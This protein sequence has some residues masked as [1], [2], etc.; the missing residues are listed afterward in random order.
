MG[1]AAL[2]YGA[3]CYLAFLASAAYAV[4][5]VGDFGVPTT[6]DSGPTLPPFESAVTDLVLLAL[7]ALQHSVMARPAFKRWWSRFV[8]H[9]IERSTYVLA[10]SVALAL[11]CWQWQPL[12]RLLWHADGVLRMALLW[13]CAAG[14]AMAV[15]S[16]F[17][18]SHTDLFGLRQT[19]LRCRA[20]RHTPVP[21]TEAALYKF[22]RHPMMLGFLIAFWSTPD[23]SEGHLLFAAATTVYILIG[24]RLEERDLDL[25]LGDDYRSYR[26]RVGMLLPRMRK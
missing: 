6:I 2:L 19:W 1:I 20:R 3:V 22:V 4:G 14:W 23:M 25:A 10:S 12:P 5:F 13:L 24:V 18:I 17:L 21:F 15:G 11:L 7:F 8:A 9:S 16:S 26:C